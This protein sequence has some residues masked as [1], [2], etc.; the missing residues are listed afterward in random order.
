MR[1][2]LVR[3]LHLFLSC[4]STMLIVG[5][6]PAL[7]QKPGFV[8]PPRTIADITV[9]LDQEKPD[10]VKRSK[11]QAEANAE[12]PAGAD[13]AVLKDFYFRRAQARHSIGRLA[14]AIADCKKAAANSSDYLNEG[15][16]I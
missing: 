14:E 7:S 2:S 9:I 11:A 13:S 3:R 1:A 10:P 16:R 6:A 5:Y 12:P 4:L 8:P 15:S